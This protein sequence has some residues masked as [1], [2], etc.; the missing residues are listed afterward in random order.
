MPQ[1]VVRGVLILHGHPRGEQR[2]DLIQRVERAVLHVFA[3]TTGMNVRA[4]VAG[5]ALHEPV[6]DRAKHPLHVRLVRRR[7]RPSQTNRDPQQVAAVFHILRHVVLA[8][9]QRD[10]V[11]DQHRHPRDRHLGGVL[12]IQQRV[13]VQ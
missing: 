5:Q 11:R 13:R 9:V 6:V 10:L 12:S 8:M 3:D 2:V 7:I 4:F 1:P